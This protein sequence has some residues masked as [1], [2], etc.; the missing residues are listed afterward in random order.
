MENGPFEDVFPIRDGDIPLL[1]LFTWGYA[2]WLRLSDDLC[3]GIVE[4]RKTSGAESWRHLSQWNYMIHD[5]FVIFSW[6]ADLNG[7][8][9]E[10]LSAPTNWYCII[11]Y[12]VTDPSCNIIEGS[13]LMRHRSTCTRIRSRWFYEAFIEQFPIPSLIVQRKIAASELKR[14]WMS[15]GLKKHQAK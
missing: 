4:W 14:V 2:V 15:L 6:V 8:R 13:V 12:S 1:C 10:K 9:S 5:L 11:C 3:W 7:S